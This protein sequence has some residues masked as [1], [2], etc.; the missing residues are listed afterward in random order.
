HAPLPAGETGHVRYRGPGVAAWFFRDE[1]AAAKSFRDGYF[2]PGDL[3]ALD[4]GGF[5]T[6]KGRSKDV[7]IRGGVNIYPPE[8]ERIASAIEGVAECCVF[9][10]PHATLDEEVGMALVLKDGAEAS[11]VQT[12]ITEECGAKLASYKLP[13]RF[14]VMDSF[15]KNSGGKVVKSKVIQAA[16]GD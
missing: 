12:R 5:L 13:R 4:E 7:I 11:T 3:G 16:L 14:Y 10:V 8:I 15:P 6:L 9:P 2:Y 1:E